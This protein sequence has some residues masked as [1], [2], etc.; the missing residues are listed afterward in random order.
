MDI[1]KL[2]EFVRTKPVQ[3]GVG[4]LALVL[5]AGVI[6]YGGTLEGTGDEAAGRCLSA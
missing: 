1:E 2:K 4:A 6:A 3:A 5:V